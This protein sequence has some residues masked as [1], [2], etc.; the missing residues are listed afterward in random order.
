M[1]PAEDVVARY[2]SG[3]MQTERFAYS[4]YNLDEHGDLL[5]TGGSEYKGEAADATRPDRVCSGIKDTL[6]SFVARL[7]SKGARVVFEYFITR[8][9]ESG[10]RPTDASPGILRTSAAQ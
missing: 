5:N 3:Q 8:R 4:A 2:E 9:G 7:H 1:A 6:R 10:Q